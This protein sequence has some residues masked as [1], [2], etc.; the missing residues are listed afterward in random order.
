[1][2]EAEWLAS[3][4]PQALLGHHAARASHRKLR[5]AAAACTRQ[6]WALL[7]DRWSREAVETAE[8]FVDRTADRHDF[9]VARTGAED[10]VLWAEKHATQVA[11]HA[12][13]AA[14]AVTLESPV[15]AA[16]AAALH[17][18]KVIGET[19]GPLLCGLLRDVFG[20]PFRPVVPEPSWMGRDGGIKLLAR[21][22]YDDRRL[23]DLSALAEALTTEN[24]REA[25]I[26]EHCRGPG[27]HVRGCWVL[28]ILTA[29]T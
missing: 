22:L 26:L 1:M 19:S 27:P 11:L 8:R 3:T 29:R 6:V 24:C 15:E 12:A 17:A 2:T 18:G 13:R 10:A 25:T 9:A 7:A 23:A 16:R 20:N 4:D 14:A 5:L 21:S 28:D